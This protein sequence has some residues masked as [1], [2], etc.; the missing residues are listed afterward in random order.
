MLVQENNVYVRNQL[1]KIGH[2]LATVGMNEWDEQIPHR[3]DA[4]AGT[5]SD[6]Q[7]EYA[8]ASPFAFSR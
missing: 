8:V 5:S 7:T 3:F 6:I 2:I 1:E 4:L